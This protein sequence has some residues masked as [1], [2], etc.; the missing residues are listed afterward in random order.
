MTGE[1]GVQGGFL[2]RSHIKATGGLL[3]AEVLPGLLELWPHTSQGAR[4][5][6]AVAHGQ[7]SLYWVSHLLSHPQSVSATGRK[8]RWQDS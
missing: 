6:G 7:R 3:L 4:S 8:E 1:H 2:D 5:K